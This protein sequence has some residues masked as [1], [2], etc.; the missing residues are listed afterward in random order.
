MTLKGPS[1]KTQALPRIGMVGRPW[2]RHAL[3]LLKTERLRTFRIIALS[4]RQPGIFFS[5]WQI[6]PVTIQCGMIDTSCYP[7]NWSYYRTIG[8]KKTENIQQCN[9]RSRH[10]CLVVAL[11]C[12]SNLLK[13]LHLCSLGKQ[14]LDIRHRVLVRL[15]YHI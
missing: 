3:G 13:I 6:S 10:L 7:V 11:F 8:N 12:K 1:L 14:V 15:G 2:C 5:G 4:L 9:G